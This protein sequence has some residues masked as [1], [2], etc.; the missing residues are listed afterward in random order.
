MTRKITDCSWSND[1]GPLSGHSCEWI[2][3]WLEQILDQVSK[4]FEV[5]VGFH[6]GSVLL[7]S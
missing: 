7:L 3:L 2:A 1:L 4:S 6:Q 5:D